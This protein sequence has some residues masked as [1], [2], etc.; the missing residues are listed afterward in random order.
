[1]FSRIL[2]STWMGPL[3]LGLSRGSSLFPKQK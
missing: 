2:L 3:G 1:M